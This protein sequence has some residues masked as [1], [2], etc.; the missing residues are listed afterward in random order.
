MKNLNTNYATYKYRLLLNT[1]LAFSFIYLILIFF[2]FKNLNYFLKPLLMLILMLAVFFSQE[3]PSKKILLFALFF[4]WGGDVILLFSDLSNIYFIVGLV[5]FL[6]SH[7]FY[8]FLFGKQKKSDKLINVRKFAFGVSILT[9]YFAVFICFL[10]AHLNNLKIPVLIYI[11]T[12]STMFIFALKG[13]LTW[14]REGKTKILIGA[15]FFIISDS[16]LSLNEFYTNIMHGTFYVMTTY[17]VAQFLIVKG[18]LDLN[19]NN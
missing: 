9:G 16:I 19:K 15:I 18:I 6:L 2:D 17:I 5:S 11:I 10:F 12:I 3:F 1:Y 4:S 8:I 14:N 7:I 13:F